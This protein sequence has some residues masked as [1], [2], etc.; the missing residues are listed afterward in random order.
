MLPIKVTPTLY[1]ASAAQTATA[2]L[3]KE[4][5]GCHKYLDKQMILVFQK[6][7]R[8]C[9]RVYQTPSQRRAAH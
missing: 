8:I 6:T 5:Q 9:N 2:C 7:K 3:Y 1:G 4:M